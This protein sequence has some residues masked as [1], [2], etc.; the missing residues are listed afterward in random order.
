MFHIG[1]LSNRP[2]L[3]AQAFGLALMAAISYVPLLQGVFHTAPLSLG[4]WALLF[5]LGS[6]VLVGDEIRKAVLRRKEVV[7]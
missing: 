5:A 3:A 4:D 1:L 2:L 7:R 6:L